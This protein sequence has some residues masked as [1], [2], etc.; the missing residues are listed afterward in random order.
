MSANFST[1]FETVVSTGLCAGCGTCVAVCPEDCIVMHD[2]E[3]DQDGDCIE[4]GNCVASCPGHE[5]PMTSLEQAVFGYTRGKTAELGVY[6]SFTAGYACDVS[7]RTGGT[8]GGLVTGLLLSLLKTG[9]ISGVVATG[10]SERHPLRA[11]PVLCRTEQEIIDA[12]LSKYMLTPQNEAL[13]GAIADDRLAL[14]ALP[15]QVAGIRKAQYFAH[16]LEHV[17]LIIGI[18]CMSNFYFEATKYLIEEV[19]G[20]DID[21][22]VSVAFRAG[23]YPGVF[24]VTTRDGVRHELPYFE[25]VES[26]PMFR[27]Y[28]CMVCEDWTGELS[29]LSVGDYWLDSKPAFSSVLVRSNTGKEAVEKGLKAGAIYLEPANEEV[30]LKGVG[31]RYK[32]RGNAKLIR[33]AQR[34]GLPCPVIT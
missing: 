18:Y 6:Q 28:R 19:I 31:F 16:T 5:I 30:I 24:A 7:I 22:V 11:V 17:T 33:E 13:K 15:C 27:P 29:D 4:C 25:A 9:E 20:L 14:V 34:H 32:K 3:P 1:L 10:Y 21:N 26:Y 8:S 12:S 23:E 2:G